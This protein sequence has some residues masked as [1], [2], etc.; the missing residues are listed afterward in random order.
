M[1]S[2][3]STSTEH[4]EIRGWVEDSTFFKLVSRG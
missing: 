4:D 2:E 3:T 1:A